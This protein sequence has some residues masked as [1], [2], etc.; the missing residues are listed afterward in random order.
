VQRGRIVKVNKRASCKTS[1]HK[2]NTGWNFGGLLDFSLARLP[3]LKAET[4]PA[5]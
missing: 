5:L 1:Y 3:G 2:P 4:S